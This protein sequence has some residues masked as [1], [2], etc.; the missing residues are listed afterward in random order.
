L[1]Q[2]SVPVRATATSPEYY[3]TEYWDDWLACAS[4]DY[5]PESD[6]EPT[7]R[8]RF[9]FDSG[10]EGEEAP[11]DARRD[12]PPR[13]LRK[14]GA[15]AFH[16]S[17]GNPR[18]GRQ[19]PMDRAIAAAESVVARE[20]GDVAREPAEEGY[21][22]QQA[23]KDARRRHYIC[24]QS[25][26]K[27]I[28][29]AKRKDPEYRVPDWSEDGRERFARAV[30]A[31]Y[32]QTKGQPPGNYVVAREPHEDGTPHYHMALQHARVHRWRDVADELRGSGLY[33][34]FVET[35]T[36]PRACRYLLDTTE[37]KTIGQ[38]DAAPLYSEGH[39]PIPGLRRV[40]DLP[41]Q[42]EEGDAPPDMKLHR[43]DV[44]SFY[45]LVVDT[46]IRTRAELARYASTD[47]RVARFYMQNGKK[48]DDHL[49]HAWEL[50][51]A[52]KPPAEELTRMQKLRAA[53]GR[54]CTCGGHWLSA[55]Q[56][57]LGAQGCAREFQIAM[58]RA[59]E[60]GRGKCC[61]VWVHGDTNSGKSFCTDGLDG[62]FEVFANCAEGSF[63]LEK[64]PG[65]DVV[66]LDDFRIEENL[67]P[68]RIFLLWCDGKRFDIRVP[69]T[70][71]GGDVTYEGDAPLIVCSKEAPTKRKYGVEDVSETEQLRA[72]FQLVHFPH[73]TESIMRT[74]IAQTP[75]QFVRRRRIAPCAHCFAKLV[76][77]P[78]VTPA[79]CLQCCT[80]TKRK[81]NGPRARLR[82][83]R[84]LIQG[85]CK[86]A[87]TYNGRQ[88][89][90]YPLARTGMEKRRETSGQVML[91]F[92]RAF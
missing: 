45:E 53:M 55:A 60:C 79:C 64:L 16:P 57:I 78:V 46:G 28:D 51:D 90:G 47:R 20:G 74:K 67:F 13:K 27:D 89:G 25:H 76:L 59:M 49:K 70:G 48:I 32:K 54:D 43:L 83:L 24:T 84:F 66:W 39:P 21:K 72:R 35:D 87:K 73:N 77:T 37:T 6:A 62:V 18:K 42:V 5:A 7:R 36:Y 38:L 19:T 12:R 65:C 11:G 58:Q 15:P 33:C 75:A 85:E 31:A 69:R 17:E 1:L 29:E 26:P 2:V 86:N 30:C 52:N 68:T 4:P 8:R 80:E 61:N 88:V 41:P 71:G 9:D 63:N 44:E 56:A 40:T 23:R 50:A 91:G 34:S 81:K 82:F 92:W 14:A 22:P 10:S 3:Y